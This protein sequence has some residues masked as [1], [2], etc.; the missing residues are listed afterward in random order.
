MKKKNLSKQTFHVSCS[1]ETV[2]SSDRELFTQRLII[3]KHAHNQAPS[4]RFYS[5]K[6]KDKY[7]VHFQIEASLVLFVIL[8]IL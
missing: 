2:T 7:G 1:R 5:N 3:T 4:R 6:S 8:S